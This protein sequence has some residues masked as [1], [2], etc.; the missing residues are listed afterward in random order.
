MHKKFFFEFLNFFKRKK[1]NFMP[2]N[3]NFHTEYYKKKKSSLNILI[4]R[5]DIKG[6][7]GFMGHTEY[8][9][10]MQNSSSPP[11]IRIKYS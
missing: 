4:S 8:V 3:Q 9:A 5:G 6:D 11:T 1:L 2:F 7:T 10:C